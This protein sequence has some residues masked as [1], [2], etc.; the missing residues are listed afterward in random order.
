MIHFEFLVWLLEDNH[1]IFDLLDCD[2]FKNIGLDDGL[3]RFFFLVKQLSWMKDESG[4]SL[5]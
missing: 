4:N 3:I 5:I 1:G 2:A